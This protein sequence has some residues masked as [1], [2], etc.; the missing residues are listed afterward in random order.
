M[1]CTVQPY[2]TYV[3]NINYDKGCVFLITLISPI[4]VSITNF[5][6]EDAVQNQ[7]PYPFIIM[8]LQSDGP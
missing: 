2:D 1:Y 7:D 3:E 5:Q 6:C 8:T 4:Q